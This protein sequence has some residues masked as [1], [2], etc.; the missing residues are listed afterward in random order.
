MM[1]SLVGFLYALA[2]GVSSDYQVIIALIGM[3]V[4][5]FMASVTLSVVSSAVAT[6]FVMFAEN[7]EA[8]MNTH[9]TEAG[10][11]SKAWKNFHGDV[12][13]ECGHGRKAARSTYPNP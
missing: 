1:T 11:L 6:V 3:F 8:L 4:G 5:F 7:P 13:N 10:I 2:A 9:K 12:F